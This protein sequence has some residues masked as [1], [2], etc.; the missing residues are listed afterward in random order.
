MSKRLTRLKA[1][2]RN[3][4]DIARDYTEVYG[5]E[6][7]FPEGRWLRET[8]RTTLKV[9]RGYGT[10]IRLETS[11]I[12]PRGWRVF[13]VNPDTGESVILFHGDDGPETGVSRASA[14]EYAEQYMTEV[15]NVGRL[16][17]GPPPGEIRE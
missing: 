1:G 12:P 8:D 17:A 15:S 9:W 13:Q 10:E 2:V 6:R 4:V 14:V 5:A 16:H 3:L 7:P 11:I